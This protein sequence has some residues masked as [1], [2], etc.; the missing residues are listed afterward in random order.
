MFSD[1]TS[2]K[3]Q[4][5]VVTVRTAYLPEQSSRQLE[6]Y[7][8]AYKI[9]I[10]NES[11]APVQLLRR[12]WFIKDALGREHI[13]AGDGVVGQQP[14]LLPG[15]SHEYIS[16]CDFTTPIGQ[17]HGFFYMAKADGAEIRVRIPKFT[18]VANFVLN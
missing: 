3:T 18:M 12:K 4:G 2:T 8:F 7:V 17:M 6:H 1:T 13:V 10:Q 9:L 11:D 15:E 5:V 16:G 14:L